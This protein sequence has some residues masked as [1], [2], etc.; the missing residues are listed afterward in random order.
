MAGATTAGRALL[1]LHRSGRAFAV[2][3]DEAEAVNEGRRPAPLP[4]APR[5]VLGVVPL[6]G[7]MRTILDPAAIDAPPAEETEAPPNSETPAFIVALRGDEQLALACERAERVEAPPFADA[8][9]DLHASNADAHVRATFRLGPLGVTLLD[10]A[11]LFEA[12][13]RGTD[14]RRHR[15]KKP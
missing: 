11:H 2:Y 9:A 12:A 5:A 14:R 8:N 4:D 15:Q 6:R 3:E 1:L 7:R 13:M 10:P